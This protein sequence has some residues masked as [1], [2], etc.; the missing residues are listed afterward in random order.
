V[1]VDTYD[2]AALAGA[3]GL[4]ENDVTFTGQA[5]RQAVEQSRKESSGESGW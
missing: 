2:K 4:G 3:A 1:L 5:D